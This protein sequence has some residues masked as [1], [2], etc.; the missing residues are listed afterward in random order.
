MQAGEQRP[1]DKLTNQEKDDFVEF[2]MGAVGLEVSQLKLQ[3]VAQGQSAWDAGSRGFKGNPGCGC[4][5]RPPRYQKGQG[6]T[7]SPHPGYGA[8]KRLPYQTGL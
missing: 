3:M 2:T 4:L 5:P 6:L 8:G 1:Y 7:G